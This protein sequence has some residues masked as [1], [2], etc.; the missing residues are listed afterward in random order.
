MAINIENTKRRV[1]PRWQEFRRALSSGELDPEEC[2]QADRLPPDSIILKKKQ[3]WEDNRTLLFAT[4]LVGA[5]YVMGQDDLAQEA[6]HFI[7]DAGQKA[8]PAALS[9]AKKVLHLPPSEEEEESPIE[10]PKKQIIY[11]NIRKLKARRIE[12]P[13]N[14]FVWCDLARLYT[15]LGLQEQASKTMQ[16][17]LG[18]AP[19]NRYVLRS[20]ARLKLHLNEPDSAHRLLRRADNVKNDPWLLAA[21]IA[22]SSVLDKTSRLIKVGFALANNE[23]IDPFHLSELSSALASVELWNGKNKMARRLFNKSLKKPNDNTLAQAAWATNYLTVDALSK[24]SVNQVHAFEA[25]S[26]MSYFEG[27]WADSLEASRAWTQEEPYS[28]RPPIQISFLMSEIFEDYAGSIDVINNA[29]RI[30]PKDPTLLNNLAFALV[31]QGDVESAQK[32]INC[33]DILNSPLTTKICITATAGLIKYRSGHPDKGKELYSKAIQVASKESLSQLKCR[34]M[35]YLA[36]EELSTRGLSADSYRQAAIQEGKRLN[37]PAIN[38][39]I[40]R[41]EKADFRKVSK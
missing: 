10:T 39:L 6:A 16:I 2:L 29:L 12:Q 15:I 19:Q 35:I 7:L 40:Q 8:S 37:D 17:A 9:V 13:R 4:D 1:V 21:E 34:A 14:A 5:A 26:L 27:N 30:I 36:R 18:L 24:E 38:V 25:I 41:L 31:N 22:T 11:G 32:A 33:I 20:A 28:R 23:S 3:E